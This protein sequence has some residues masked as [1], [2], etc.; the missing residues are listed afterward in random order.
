MAQKKKKIDA[1]N[2]PEVVHKKY[3]AKAGMWV[4]TTV[5]GQNQTQVW[6]QEKPAA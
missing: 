6:S 1:D 4:K 5:K 2:Q 3:V